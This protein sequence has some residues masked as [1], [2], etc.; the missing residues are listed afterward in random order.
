MTNELLPTVS[1]E[2]T[3]YVTIYEKGNPQTSTETPPS[4][5]NTAVPT[6]AQEEVKQ[7]IITANY[8]LGGLYRKGDLKQLSQSDCKEI[9]SRGET[10]RKY[11]ADLKQNEATHCM[12]IPYKSKRKIKFKQLKNKPE[13]K[14]LKSRKKKKNT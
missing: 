14:F 8:I 2:T 6:T 1:Q 9:I 11:K 13:Q 4:T 12:Q 3:E 5:T 7:K 10:L